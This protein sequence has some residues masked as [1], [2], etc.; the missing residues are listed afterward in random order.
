L[1]EAHGG[2]KI[3]LDS[4]IDEYIETGKKLKPF[5]TNTVYSMNKYF[6][7]GKR[8]LF[9]GAQGILLDINFGTYPFVTSSNP[10]VGGIFCGTGL[11]HKSLGKVTGISKAYTTRVGGGPFPSELS[12]E[13]ADFLRQEGN[14]YGATT[15]RPRRVGWLDLVGLK[16]AIM[17][18]GVDEIF[19][20]KLDV[21]DNFDEICVVTSYEI[22]GRQSEIFN[23]SLDYLENVKPVL[24]TFPGWKTDL[25]GITNY[26]DLPSRA[27]EYIQFVTEFI[28][29]PLNYI[30]VGSKRHQT[31]KR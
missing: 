8:I 17:L 5:A 24:K 25:S 10:T 15:G 23:P 29:V 18:N 21:L 22:D 9:E 14:E 12:G 31:I 27:V 16:Y 20:T 4:Y 6:R 26:D 1:I 19:F 30:S 11:S 2:D 3:E 13:V 7:E 28:G